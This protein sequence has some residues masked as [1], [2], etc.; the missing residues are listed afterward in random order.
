[1]LEV[2][3][4]D[5]FLFFASS[6]NEE[7]TVAGQ[8]KLAAWDLFVRLGGILPGLEEVT[9]LLPGFGEERVFGQLAQHGDGLLNLLNIRLAARAVG[10]V[11]L[12]PCLRGWEE[13]CFQI[14]GD[15][16]YDFF[17]TEFI[18]RGHHR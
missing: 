2:F 3:L 12:K 11:L 5:V 14:F 9:E 4:L 13:R 6:G 18:I 16:S 8:R 7:R 17:T 15:E 1:M 10:N